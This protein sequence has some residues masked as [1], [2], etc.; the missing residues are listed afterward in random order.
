M[1]GL[2]KSLE[3]EEEVLGKLM[4]PWKLSLKIVN[5]SESLPF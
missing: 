5:Y 4:I 3:E 1:K 2:R